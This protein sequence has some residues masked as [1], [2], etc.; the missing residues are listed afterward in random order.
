M[1]EI[2]LKNGIVFDTEK[3]FDS[4]SSEFQKYMYD[5]IT[6][7]SSKET[8]D[9]YGRITSELFDDTENQMSFNRTAKYLDTTTLN[10]DRKIIINYY[11]NI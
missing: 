5:F 7:N 4:Q 2:T 9:E 10:A 11:G 8:K 3:Y 6:S 1:A